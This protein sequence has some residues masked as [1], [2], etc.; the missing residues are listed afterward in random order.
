V[1]KVKVQFSTELTTRLVYLFQVRG[2]SVFAADLGFL[3]EE[4][5]ASKGQF[6]PRVR[7]KRKSLFVATIE[8]ANSLINS[9]I[10]NGRINSVGL[11]V[12]DEVSRFVCKICWERCMNIFV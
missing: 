4:Y 1:C 2:L 11:V 10:E 9:L 5:A 12:V 6:P 7:R 3:V 8:K